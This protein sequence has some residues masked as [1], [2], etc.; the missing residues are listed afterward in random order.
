[1]EIRQL[2]Y[3]VHAAKTLSF[4][5]AARLSHVAQSTLSQQVKQ[6]EEEL[7][8]PLFHRLGKRIALTAEGELFL[9]D[10]TRLLDDERQALQRLADLSRLEGGTVTVGIA[11]GLGL[12][13]VLSDALTEYN[14]A[15]PHV[16]I[17]IRQ[18]AAPLLTDRL[19]NHDIDVALTF[20]PGKEEGLQVSPLFATRLCAVVGEHHALSSRSTLSLEEMAHHALVLPSPDMSVRQRL[21]DMARKQGIGLSPAVEVDDIPH[22]IYMVRLGHWTTILPDAAVAAIRG[23]TRIPLEESVLMPTYILTLASS[24]QRKAVTEFLRMLSESSRL[25]LQTGSDD[26]EV[27]GET[28][29]V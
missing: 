15:Y 24:Y 13:A 6:L 5:E 16:E 21:D 25:M 12:S 19:R 27:C 28:F 17:R 20:S 26:C 29:L 14:K 7:G 8:V 4:T 18:L 10:A 1:M 9:H 11:S 2:H 3:F 22:I 23:I